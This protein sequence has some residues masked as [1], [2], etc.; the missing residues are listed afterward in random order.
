MKNV[1]KRKVQAKW[2]R[3]FRKIH[4]ITGVTLVVF[5]LIIS[6]TGIL[7]GWKKHS[8]GLILAKSHKGTSTDLK[9]WLP[10]DSLH[11]NACKILFDS[12]SPELSPELHRIDI[13]KE[14]GMAK[15]VFKHHFTAIQL[16]GA[17]GDLLHIEVRRSDFI[18]EMHDGSIL[19]RYFKTSNQQIKLIYTSMMG[20]ALLLFG[21]TGFWL[22]Y[23]RK[24]MERQSPGRIAERQ[25]KELSAKG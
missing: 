11:T 8:S 14:S 6:S 9:N 1:A 25:S 3:T 16:D 5:I 19:D 15:F 21:I 17:T 18:E 7:L 10:L 22:W 2:L 12:V 13:R 23:G 24:R 4:R 20:L